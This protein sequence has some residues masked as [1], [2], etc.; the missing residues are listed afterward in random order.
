MEERASISTVTGGCYGEVRVMR[1][2]RYE[3]D[4][5][6]IAAAGDT[7]VILLFV[8]LGRQAH[9]EAS[10]G[11]SGM[12]TVAAPFLVGWFASAG[13]LGAFRRGAFA[14]YRS[15][16]VRV[17]RSWVAGC[18]VGLVIRSIVEHRIVPASFALVAFGVNLVLLL[19]WRLLLVGSMRVR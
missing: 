2:K 1:T 10:G 5:P 19:A 11:A 18:A 9:R 3:I 17:V 6:I 12:L 14:G 15:A 13:A 8:V 16:V 7:A 4:S